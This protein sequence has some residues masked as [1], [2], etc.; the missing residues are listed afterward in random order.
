M[1]RAEDDVTSQ[2]ESEMQRMEDTE[3]VVSGIKS[4]KQEAFS[5]S[6]QLL[7]PKE[8]RGLGRAQE[9]YTSLGT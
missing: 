3:S 7:V 1:M 8:L 9:S 6:N 4:H 2:S 5:G